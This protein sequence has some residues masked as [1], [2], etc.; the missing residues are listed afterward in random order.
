[1]HV[2]LNKVFIYGIVVSLVLSMTENLSISTLPTP[3]TTHKS[4]IYNVQHLLNSAVSIATSGQG[5][6]LQNCNSGE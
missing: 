3:T 2:Y 6:Q 1:M 4:V 5:T